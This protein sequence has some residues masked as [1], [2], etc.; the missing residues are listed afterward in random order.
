[1]TETTYRIRSLRKTRR[2]QIDAHGIVHVAYLHQATLLPGLDMVLPERPFA[3]RR[4]AALEVDNVKK[5][6]YSLLSKKLAR[7]NR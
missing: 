5:E 1:M 6:I 7:A 2:V 3:R 4:F